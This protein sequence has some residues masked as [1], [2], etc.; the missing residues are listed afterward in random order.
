MNKTP[1]ILILLAA[2]VGVAGYYLGQRQTPATTGSDNAPARRDVL[3]WKAPMD[4]NFRSDKPGTS[5][6]GMELVPVYADGGGQGADVKIEPAVVNNLGVHTAAVQQGPLARRVEAVGYVAYD[7]DSLAAVNTRADGWVE[8]LAVKSVGEPV[9]RGQVLYELFSPKRMSAEREYL[10]ALASG[11]TTLIAASRQ[12]LRALGYTAKQIERLKRKRKVGE[13][14]ARHAP[15]DGVVVSLG[16]REGAYVKPATQVMRIA[17]LG[18]VWVLVAVDAADAA[19]LREGQTAV[20][21]FDAF[22]GQKWQG[23]VDYIYPELNA[24]TRTLKLRLRFANPER[25]LKPNMYA[26]V[27]IQVQPEENALSIPAQALIR[28]GRS[29]RVIVALGDGRFNVCPVEAGLTAGDRVQI[30]NGLQPGQRVVTSAQFMLDS[31]A[32]VEAAALR[33]GAGRSGCDE[34]PAPAADHAQDA[35]Q[36]AADDRATPAG[37][38]GS[39]P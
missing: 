30:L 18:T 11:R 9:R 2:A 29:Q 16:V 3:Y 6:M 4:P 7:E 38:H 8:T 24:Q 12:R 10:T 5:P 36:H 15:R 37:N 23:K 34:A 33:L 27:R 28:T 26:N 22:P 35:S 1:V 19:W 31:E 21:R 39:Q 13:R 17:D 20:A 14:V 32:N 25:R